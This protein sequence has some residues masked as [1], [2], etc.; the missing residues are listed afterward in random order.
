VHPIDYANACPDISITS[1]HYYF[2]WA[3]ST[4]LKWSVFCAVSGR[5]PRLDLDTSMYFE[6]ADSDRTYEEKLDEYRRLADDYFEIERYQEFCA[7]SLSTVDDLV[8]DWVSSP[9]FDGLLTQ[10]VRST[11]PAAEHERFLAH[12]RGLLGLWVKDNS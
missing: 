2:P 11:Y 3:I 10:T 8:R 6:V 7:E 9:A 12:F 1:L 4:L 5:R